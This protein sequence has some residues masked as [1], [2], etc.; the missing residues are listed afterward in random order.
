VTPRLE[1]NH[2]RPE[3]ALP[4]T[5]LISADLLQSLIYPRIR[6]DRTRVLDQR[7]KPRGR[8]MPA[9]IA[10]SNATRARAH[11]R[12]FRYS[13][14]SKGCDRS[15]VCGGTTT[16]RRLVAGA[17]ADCFQMSAEAK[18]IAGHV[19]VKCPMTAK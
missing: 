14:V 2:S 19:G 7:K 11:Y 9:H 10:R 6:R 5:A 12:P 13:K 4:D 8:K 16:M 3:A 1:S 18:G 17:I 15:D